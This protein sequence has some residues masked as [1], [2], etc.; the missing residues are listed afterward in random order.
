MKLKQPKK[1]DQFKTQITDPTYSLFE[2]D[3]KTPLNLLVH[4]KIRK[5]F[6]VLAAKKDRKNNELFTDIFLEYIKKNKISI[7]DLCK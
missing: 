4:K 5:A 2:N 3:Q 6:T 7:Q 1:K